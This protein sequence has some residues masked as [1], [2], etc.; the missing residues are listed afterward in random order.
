MRESFYH[1]KWSYENCEPHTIFISQGQYT[2]KGLH[3]LIKAIPLIKRVYPDVKV[4]IAGADVLRGGWR[5][6]G[7]KL[8][9]SRLIE[10]TNSS[11]ALEFVGKLD[12]QKM[13]DQF[14]AA[15]VFV[16]PSAIENSSNSIGEAQLLG[17]PIIASYVGGNAE[18]LGY[19]KDSLYRFEE[20][21]MLAERII[22][23]FQANRNVS[24]PKYNLERYDP[25][26]NAQTLI[27]IYHKIA[28]NV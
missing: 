16:C 1:H 25:I 9:L 8:Y 27:S 15:N 13:C 7:Y 4:R 12:E 17:M 19:S 6:S 21:E 10:E 14:L 23:V 3:Q 24:I 22:S 18:L 28:E 5:K 2:I 11:S 26:Q 20:Y